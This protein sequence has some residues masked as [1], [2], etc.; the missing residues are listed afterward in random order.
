MTKRFCDLCKGDLSYELNTTI[1]IDIVFTLS[2]TNTREYP[3]KRTSHI[4]IHDIC[5]HCAV[6]LK[7]IIEEW[8]KG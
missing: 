2:S 3:F 8:K 6:K 7:K 1:P 4:D 5:E